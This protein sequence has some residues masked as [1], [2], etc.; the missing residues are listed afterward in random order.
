MSGSGRSR[1]AAC[2]LLFC[3]LVMFSGCAK[4]PAQYQEAPVQGSRIS[5]PISQVNDGNAHFYSYR[6]SGRHINFFV[7]SDSKGAVS[8]Y[9]DA[10]YTCYK[11]K[12]G[13]R[14]EGENLICNE[15]SMK[16]GLSEETWSERDGCDPIPLNSA[17]EDNRLLI[18]TTVIEKGA[19]LF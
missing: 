6:K 1:I 14:Q 18:D 11:K 8:A 4:Q 3:C 17:R 7:R 12:K 19:K 5:I 16:F 15:C 10:C 2:S 13:Y 9:F